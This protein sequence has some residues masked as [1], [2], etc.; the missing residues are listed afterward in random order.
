VQ[1]DA[2]AK[3]RWG[4]ELRLQLADRTTRTVTQAIEF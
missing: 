1:Q 4:Q 3:E 2:V